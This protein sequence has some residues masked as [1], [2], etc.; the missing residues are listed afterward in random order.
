MSHPCS[1]LL[2]LN[3]IT[4]TLALLSQ[5]S[6][7]QLSPSFYNSTCSNVSAIVRS[8]VQQAQT[9]D[10]RIYASL[11]RLFFHD[12]FVQGCDGSV[13]LVN[14]STIQTEQDAVPN[15]NSIRGFNVVADIKTAVE[16]ACPGVVSCADILALTAEASVNLAGGPSWTVLL[17]RRDSTTANITA[18]NNLPSPFDNL[19][20]LEQKFAAV[21]LND[22]DLVTLSGAHTFGRGQCRFVTPR[23][24][25]FSSTVNTDPTLN[26]TYATTLEQNCPQGG[27]ASVLNNLD[28]ITPNTFDSNYY[29]NLQNHQGLFT[30][31]QEL[32]SDPNATTTA[33][34]VNN[35]AG[36]QSAFFDSFVQS[37]INMGNISPLTGSSGEIRTNCSVVNSGSGLELH[38]RIQHDSDKGSAAE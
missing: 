12:C 33:S 2:A 22:T 37:M 26:S 31:D 8:T 29:I 19:T 23:L 4:I 27:N 7:A 18:A 11:T 36:N 28:P 10:V 20:T 17:G 30:S 25:N 6:Q 14:S 32:L 3:L 21:G 35:F 15:K 13:L 38:I 1:L 9:S 16:N 24:Y 5:R 34:I